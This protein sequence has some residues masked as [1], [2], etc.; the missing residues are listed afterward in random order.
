VLESSDLTSSIIRAA[1][2]CRLCGGDALEPVIDLGDHH[3]SG[4]FIDGDAPEGLD[5]RLPL[6]VVR[7]AD[8][9]GC[10]LVQLAHS[11]EPSVMYAHYG[12]RSGTNEIMRA[13]LRDIAEKVSALAPLRPGDHVLD[14]GCN[15][16]TLMAAYRTPG[17]RVLGVDPSD[18]ASEAEAAGFEVVRAFFSRDAVEEARPGTRFRAIT[19]IAMFYD[20]EDPVAFARDVEA[21]LTDDGVWVVELSYLPTM[22]TRCSF[23]TVCHEHLEY[24]ALGS[25][26]WAL[27]QSGLAVEHVEF[28]EINGGS[29]RLFIRKADT[30]G[31]PSEAVLRARREEAGMQLRSDEPYARFREATEHV[32]ADLRAMLERLAA[33]GR[34]VYAYGASTKGNTILQYCGIDTRLV[35]K[36]A[37]RNPDKWGK[38]TLGT[39]IP[40]VSEDEARREAPDYF[41]VLPWHFLDGFLRREAPYLEAGGMFI[42]PIPEVRVIGATR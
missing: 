36:A 24:Y 39:R 10:G 32:R 21:L 6:A 29:F 1:T 23:D 35:A 7:C 33:D 20:L 11:V 41:L 28:N 42:V 8:P 18:A 16:G 27:R 26:E 4:I 34:R 17:L 5:E 15:D 30:V 25:I 38:R 3:L 31:Q 14:I 19:S 22:L 9:D 40:I 13:N 37:D 12:Y 2:R